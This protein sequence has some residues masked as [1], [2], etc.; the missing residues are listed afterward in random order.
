MGVYVHVTTLHNS[1]HNDTFTKNENGWWCSCWKESS[2][3]GR[4]LGLSR[5]PAI[6]VV[7]WGEMSASQ[8]NGVMKVEVAE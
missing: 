5:Y 6:I 1:R 7:N 2:D 8:L 4:Q 3:E